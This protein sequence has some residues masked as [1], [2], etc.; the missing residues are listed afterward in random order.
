M[1]AVRP[2]TAGRLWAYAAAALG[3]LVS[4]AA[5][6]AHTYVPPADLVPAELAAWSPHGGAVALSGRARK[7]VRGVMRLCLDHRWGVR[8][9][10]CVGAGSAGR[11]G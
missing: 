10:R 7:F 8:G 4:I 5:N 1:S 6:V 11:V 9:C 2:A 3:G